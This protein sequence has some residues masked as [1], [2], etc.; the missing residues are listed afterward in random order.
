VLALPQVRHHRETAGSFLGRHRGKRFDLMV[1]DMKME[2]VKAARL[3][4]DS[5]DALGPG[6]ALLTT[7]KLAKGPSALREIEDS[8]RTLESAYE[9]RHARQLYFNRSEITVY[10]R[11]ADRARTNPS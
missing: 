2:A 10:A 6:G 3:L 9:I 4:V 11:R 7:L 5:A 8:L 1:S